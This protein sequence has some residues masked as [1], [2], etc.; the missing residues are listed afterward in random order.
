MKEETPYSRQTLINSLLTVSHNK[1]NLYTQIGL[2]AGK[3]EPEL[4]AH[5]LAWNSIH[6]KVRDSKVAFPVLALR[7]LAAPDRDLVENAVANLLLLTPRKLIQAYEFSTQLSAGGI[8]KRVA[9]G[10][11]EITER[12]ELGPLV[13]PNHSRKVLEA[14]I[15]H[16]L[17]W[18]EERP[19]R[20]NKTAV[21]YRDALLRLYKIAH[22]KPSTW[23]QRIL[24]DRD[25][26]EG[27]IFRKIATLSHMSPQ[28]AAATIL[29]Y[30]LPLEIAMGAYKAEKTTEFWLAVITGMTGNQLVTNAK[31]LKKHK[32]F[33]SAVL[34]AAYDEALQKAKKS[35]R[36]FET[37]KASRAVEELDD[38]PELTEKLLSLQR[39]KSAQLAG[40]E[41]D[42]LVLADASGSMSQSLDLGRKIAALIAEQVKGQVWLI[43]FDT[44]PTPFEVTGL[45]F[46]QIVAK[47]KRIQAGGGTAIGCGLDY[48]LQRRATVHG[49]AIVSDGGDNT[50]PLFANSYKKYT[51]TMGFEPTVYLYH[52]DGEAD[53]LTSMLKHDGVMLNR[54][55][56][57]SN[58]DY[59]S[60][61]A[62]VATMHTNR[63]DQVDKIMATPLLT[64]ADVLKEKEAA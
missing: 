8:Y 29:Q 22:Q 26:P 45:S 2:L 44:A 50:N 38:D 17:T 11:R 42:W 52:V 4:F 53:S 61:P 25:Y 28:D 41:G 43:F 18:R 60:L 21:R 48:L 40:I 56:M 49:I 30:D 62:L 10:G 59:Y 20:W 37:L 23:A 19:G 32:V 1:L 31:M 9:G 51:S 27:S 3:S 57:S 7:T 55:E 46:D 5:F 35:G 33:D 6:G 14:G 36:S 12:F 16:Y 34:K 47:T 24:F 39:T 58:V 63:Y 54:F 15:R 64:F 13:L